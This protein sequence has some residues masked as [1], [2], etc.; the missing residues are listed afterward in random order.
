MPKNMKDLAQHSVNAAKSK[1]SNNEEK[2]YVEEL[3][4]ELA[5]SSEAIKPSNKK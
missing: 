5:H 4:S 1:A 3:A 2:H